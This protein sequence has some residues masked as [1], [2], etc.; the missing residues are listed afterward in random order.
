V[1]FYK[2]GTLVDG[3]QVVCLTLADSRNGHDLVIIVF[4]SDD[5]VD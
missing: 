3:Y 2:R 4:F 1:F 5:V